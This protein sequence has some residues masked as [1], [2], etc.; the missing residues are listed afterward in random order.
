MQNIKISAVS[1]E[2]AKYFLRFNRAN[3]EQIAISDAQLWHG[4]YKG[5]ILIGVAGKTETAKTARIKGVYERRHYRGMGVATALIKSLVE[6]VKDKEITAFASE[7]S[8]PTF[9]KF[10]FEEESTNK[11]NITFVRRKK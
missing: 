2:D 7:F 11:N 1:N 6:T 5:D 8:L 10:G 9:K 4:A 3:R